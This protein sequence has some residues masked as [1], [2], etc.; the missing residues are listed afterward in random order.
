MIPFKAE[1]MCVLGQEI[2]LL[3]VPKEKLLYICTSQQIQD[4]TLVLLALWSKNKWKRPKLSLTRE[5]KRWKSNEW[6]KYSSTCPQRW[7][8]KI[9][10]WMRKAN[11]RWWQT[12]SY[13]SKISNHKQY[14]L[15]KKIQGNGKLKL[16]NYG[17]FCLLGLHFNKEKY[18]VNKIN[19]ENWWWECWRDKRS[20]GK[21]VR[22]GWRG[23]G[24]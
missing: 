6:M 12:F 24:L 16:E 13:R 18:R 15:L 23:W 11:L 2:P 8:S 14:V 1:N 22:V 10:R 4:F 21:G 7:I 17:Y 9:Y 20:P 5:W 19:N 3:A